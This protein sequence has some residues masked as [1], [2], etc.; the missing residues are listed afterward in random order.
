LANDVTQNAVFRR[1]DAITQSRVLTRLSSLVQLVVD[2]TSAE[3]L[4]PTNFR[5]ILGDVVVEGAPVVGT[6]MFEVTPSGA[7]AVMFAAQSGAV[8]LQLRPGGLVASGPITVNVPSTAGVSRTALT[9][10]DQLVS[11]PN[12]AWTAA[13]STDDGT[14]RVGNLTLSKRATGSGTPDSVISN[15]AGNIDFEI[16]GSRVLRVG[17][18]KRLTLSIGTIKNDADQDIAFVSSNSDAFQFLGSLVT[19]RF[20]SAVDLTVLSNSGPATLYVMSN[21]YCRLSF[22]RTNWTDGTRTSTPQTIWSSRVSRQRA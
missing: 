19:G 13:A 17:A 6:R 15:T 7:N 18:D 3:L 22:A 8:S 5:I 2:N 10:A 4:T 20:S 21:D 1:L 16:G 9:I 11:T 12:V 14:L